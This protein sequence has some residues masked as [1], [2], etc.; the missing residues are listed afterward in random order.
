MA[1]TYIQITFQCHQNPG[2][3]TMKVSSLIEKILYTAT[4]IQNTTVR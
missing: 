4:Q 2:Q 1:I 3:I